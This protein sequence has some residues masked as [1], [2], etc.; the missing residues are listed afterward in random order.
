VHH[1]EGDGEGPVVHLGVEDVLVVDDHGEGEED[2]HRHV[3]VRDQDLADHRLRHAAVAA[4][5]AGAG[6]FLAHG[7]PLSRA[8]SRCSA[9]VR[10]RGGGGSRLWSGREIWKGGRQAGK[11]EEA[12]LGTEVGDGGIWSGR[13]GVL[14]DLGGGG[15]WPRGQLR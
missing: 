8:P 3:H 6:P 1:G 4:A 12:D 7:W 2:P 10:G 9:P 14:A 15:C 5:A 13:A 11:E